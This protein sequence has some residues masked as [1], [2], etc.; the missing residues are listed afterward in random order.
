VD[1]AAAAPARGHARS[2]QHHLPRPPSSASTTST[3][4]PTVPNFSITGSHGFGFTMAGW[5]GTGSGDTVAR[6]HVSDAFVTVWERFWS[7]DLAKIIAILRRRL[8]QLLPHARR[9]IAHV[10]AFWGGITYLRRA[11]A[12]FIRILNKD[13]RVRELL[14]RMAWASASTLRVFLSMCAMTLHAMLRF[15]ALMRDKIIPELRLVLPRYYSRAVHALHGMAVRSPWSTALGPVSVQVALHK[16]KLPDPDWL[17][18]KFGVK[19]HGHAPSR[20]REVAHVRAREARPTTRAREAP[21]R[22]SVREPPPVS[23]VAN[24][25]SYVYTYGTGTTK[26]VDENGATIHSRSGRERNGE[27]DDDDEDASSGSYEYT[28]GSGVDESRAHGAEPTTGATSYEYA[29]ITE[30]NGD[31]QSIY[32]GASKDML[33]AKSAERHGR[34]PAGKENMLRGSPVSR[35]LGYDSDEDPDADL[36]E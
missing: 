1:S 26:Y 2:A 22:S 19:P 3:K 28:Y 23:T 27:D 11:F 35:Q 5:G 18:N 24:S 10:V 14:E 33:A 20:A 8:N 34:Q 17:H 6:Q 4:L 15:Y 25:A 21:L 9:F 30:R 12:A 32:P 7:E 36:F 31:S 29:T 16:N 13:S